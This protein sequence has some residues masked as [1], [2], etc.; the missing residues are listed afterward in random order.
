[1]NLNCKGR[2]HVGIVLHLLIVM[3]AVS[4]A[5]AGAQQPTVTLP[6]GATIEQAVAEVARATGGVVVADVAVKERTLRKPLTNASLSDALAAISVDFDRYWVWRGPNIALQLRYTDPDEPYALDHEEAQ[7][8]ADEL[9]GILS[10]VTPIVD[11]LAWLRRKYAFLDSITAAQ[12]ER[13]INGGLPVL[14][15][16]RQQQRAVFTLNGTHA[17][18]TAAREALNLERSLRSESR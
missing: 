10:D 7:T 5:F 11:Q 16:S 3:L 18:R 12:Q 2:L 14:A 17:F 13:M 9:A 4:A 15:L 8:T 6:A 1:M